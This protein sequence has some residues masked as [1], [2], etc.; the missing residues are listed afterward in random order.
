MRND[1]APSVQW[2]IA[3]G[4][5]C[6]LAAA[7]CLTGPAR[8]QTPN[9]DPPPVDPSH[10]AVITNGTIKLGVRDEGHL[11][12]AGVGI[13][14]IQS[15]TTAVGL[16]LIFPD[17]TESEATAPGCLCEGWGASGD[18]VAG[19]K[20]ESNGSSTNVSLVSFTAT[21]STALSVVEILDAGGEIPV[22]VLRVTHDFHPAA[23]TSLLYEVTVTLENVSDAPI[24]D[25]RYRR[26]MDWDIAP[27][28]FS[29]FVTIETGNAVDIAATT[30][31]GFDTPN[32]LVPS[33]PAL[34][35]G[36]AV[37]SGPS[38]H[39]ALFQFEFADVTP[40]TPLAPG[41]SKSFTIFYGGA[42][43][44]PDAL[45]ALGAVGAEA[46]SFGQP[47]LSPPE[48]H[49]EPNTFIF[50][51]QGVGGDPVVPSDPVVHP[52]V[53]IPGWGEGIATFAEGGTTTVLVAAQQEGLLIFQYQDPDEPDPDPIAQV[54]LNGSCSF[55]DVALADH[56]AF[57]AAGS[58]GMAVVDVS[59]PA[60]PEVRG[61]FDDPSYVKDVAVYQ[62]DGMTQAYV[63]DYFGGL[64]I[65]D[66]MDPGAPQD[67]SFSATQLPI[68]TGL[69][70]NPVAVHADGD[71][72]V[73]V[74]HT[75][76][77]SIVDATV[78]EVLGSCTT[79]PGGLP[80]NVLT[81]V[82][83]DVV[84]AGDQVY[85]PIWIE[86]L[87]ALDVGDPTELS[88]TCDGQSVE[89]QQAFYKAALSSDGRRLFVTE[90]QCGLAV[91]DV[92]ETGLE[93]AEFSQLPIADGLD[94]KQASPPSPIDPGD[95][96]AWGLHVRGSVVG[97]SAGILEPRGGAWQI[98]D[99]PPKPLE[100]EAPEE[101]AGA[102]PSLGGSCGLLGL[103]P[104]AVWWPL[105]A[106]RRRRIL[107][108]D[109][110]QAERAAS[111]RRAKS[112]R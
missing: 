29:E 8:A 59:D 12:I 24:G 4:S 75:Q 19:W 101:P 9:D 64:W 106:L 103:E 77:L 60:V 55:D 27:T 22:P 26:L 39:G 97:V 35:S 110:E 31:N 13:P 53:S 102:G 65:V 76:G 50:A 47:N 40:E 3:C 15:G 83:Q 69:A 6:A 74:A 43:N 14:S 80:L 51:F 49:G 18:A 109:R 37:D 67:L 89:T 32:P 62:G 81:S 79:N 36:E 28:T 17:E 96:F 108:R 92:T 68:G 46:Y 20:S 105:R 86:G 72:R 91:F 10:S 52:P 45:A 61:V 88:G 70:G 104:L 58:C 85:L 73:Y 107:E 82:P 87:L 54:Q 100:E 5:A 63:G 57:V 21:D 90:G 34:F 30:D 99:I 42:F 25:L 112:E 98:L 1:A 84:A 78:P 41:E 44:E 111:R 66:V 2:W 38:D 33:S 7:L 93:E 11:N 56:L 23:Q 94:C 16:R 95:P 71:E 48:D